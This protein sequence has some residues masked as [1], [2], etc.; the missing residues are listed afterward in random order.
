MYFSCSSYP[1]MTNWARGDG[2]VSGLGFR[3]SEDGP[4][5]VSGGTLAD[6]DDLAVDGVEAFF[7]VDARAA[8]AEGLALPGA[9]A[10]GEQDGEAVTRAHGVGE[11]E[12]LV[13][14][15]DAHDGFED[16]R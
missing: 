10:V 7:A 1:S 11:V 13:G 16:L 12:D 14:G 15:E 6:Q 5:G 8:G 4:R 3:W 9:G 2:A